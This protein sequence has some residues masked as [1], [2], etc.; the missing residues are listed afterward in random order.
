MDHVFDIDIASKYGVDCAIIIHNLCFWVYKNQS[1][2][3]NFYDGH[4]WTYNSERAFSEIFPYW[5]RRQ[6]QT[7]LNKLKKNSIIEVGNYNKKKYDRTNWYT[8]IDK[9][10]L[11]KYKINHAETQENSPLN[12]SVQSIEQNGAMSENDSSSDENIKKEDSISEMTTIEQNGAMHSTKMFNG[13]HENVQPIPY[14]NTD[15]KTNDNKK[16]I[17]QSKIELNNFFDLIWKEYPFKRGKGKVSDKT[18][19]ELYKLGFDKLKM[20]I[21]RYK[22]D[23][24][25][26]RQDFEGLNYLN[27]STFFNSGYLDYIKDDFEFYK[28]KD[29]KEAK[30]R[31]KPIQSTNYEQRKYDDEFFDNL[32]DNVQ[33][34]K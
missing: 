28:P 17:V 19:K 12:N 32:Y 23:V 11:K 7:I 18:K 22:K 29:K 10:I 27:G 25:L 4:Y 16:N 15:N 3:K 20:I 34:I 24:E 9:E 33:Y 2:K 30:I 14:I 21:E 26:R 13:L 6:I 1:N 8:V 31:D 5:S